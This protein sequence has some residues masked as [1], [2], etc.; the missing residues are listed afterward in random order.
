MYAPAPDSFFPHK[1]TFIDGLSKHLPQ[2]TQLLTWVKKST[3][4]ESTPPLTVKT[5]SVNRKTF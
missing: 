4:A 5:T 1:K 3:P 2:A